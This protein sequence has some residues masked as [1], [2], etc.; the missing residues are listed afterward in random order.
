MVL[1]AYWQQKQTMAKQ[2]PGQPATPGQGGLKI[3]PF[4]LWF[5]SRSN[6]PAGLVVYFAASQLF[7]IGQQSLI[8]GMDTKS[9]VA[10]PGR[11]E[12]QFVT[13]T[14]TR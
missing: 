10:A 6:L 11:T 7:R 5:H 8:L 14:R 2:P 3:F 12:G 4:V 9:M 1:T 13:S